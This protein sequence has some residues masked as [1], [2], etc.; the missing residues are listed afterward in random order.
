LKNEGNLLPLKKDIASLYIVG[1]HASSEEVLLGNYYGLSGNTVSI[2]DGIVSR[3]SLG[4]S[5]NY[6]MGV[7][8]YR[9]NVN[10]ID[11]STGEAKRSDVMIAVMGISGLLEGEEGESLASDEKGDRTGIRLPQHQI[12][13]LKKLKG[14]SETPLVL[15]VT[16]G[17]PIAMPEVADLADAILFAWYPGE[18]G[19]NAIADI[20]F[21]EVSPSGKLPVTFPY[22]VDELPAF[23]DYTMKNRTYKYMTTTPQYPFGYGLSYTTFAYSDLNIEVKKKTC[24][25]Q[26]TLKNEGSM[27]ADEVVQLYISS[28]LA[29]TT[30]PISSLRGFQRVALKAGTSKVVSFELQPSDFEQFNED[31]EPVL[32]KG[33]YTIHVGNASPG[34]RSK[35][36]G[37]QWLIATVDSKQLD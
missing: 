25:V 8:P 34:S 29:K 19:G 36:L 16:G 32:R 30:D 9:A 11:W 37:G 12:D 17:S 31:G 13:Y 22:G 15:I 18:E 21:G 7:L 4:T 28:P 1:P 3:V 35:E 27:A 26:V 14:K 6:K 24:R 10:P 23:E 5:I 33:L 20:L 2:L